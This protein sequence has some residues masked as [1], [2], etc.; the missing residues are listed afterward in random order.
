MVIGQ[1]REEMG[2]L[3]LENIKTWLDKAMADLIQHWDF[4]LGLET[5]REPFQPKLL[6]ISGELQICSIFF[7]LL[8]SKAGVMS[9]QCAFPG[10]E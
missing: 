5:F 3:S 6:G 10:V 7:L 9:G 4:L 1:P 2:R 8:I